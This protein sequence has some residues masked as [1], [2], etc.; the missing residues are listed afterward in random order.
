MHNIRE[1]IGR[2]IEIQLASRSLLYL[3]LQNQVLLD[4]AY[5][6]LIETRIDVLQCLLS[7]GLPIICDAKG[8][9]IKDQ[10]SFLAD[11]VRRRDLET[12]SA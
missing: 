2:T 8:L 6:V 1:E 11:S 3:P 10:I 4:L 12:K 5:P 9:C 7:N